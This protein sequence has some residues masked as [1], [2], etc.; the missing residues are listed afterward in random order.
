MTP[1]PESPAPFLSGETSSTTDIKSMSL[2]HRILTATLVVGILALV[3]CAPVE[4][5]QPSPDELVITLDYENIESDVEAYPITHNLDT[6]S[7]MEWVTV[8]FETLEEERAVLSIRVNPPV[9]VTDS[10]L[11][12]V[13]EKFTETDFTGYSLRTLQVEMT[14]LTSEGRIIGS[15]VSHLFVPYNANGERSGTVENVDDILPCT[16]PLVAKEASNGGVQTYCLLLVEAAYDS[17]NQFSYLD[18][19]DDKGITITFQS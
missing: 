4:P 7:F 15:P 5:E 8:P 17:S 6:V 11:A 12:A 13:K 14:V 3:G 16:Y 2:K 1:L 10:V 9:A 19:T 18:Y